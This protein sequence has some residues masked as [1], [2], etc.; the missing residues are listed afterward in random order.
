MTWGLIRAES[1]GNPYLN[2]A[3]EEFLFKNLSNTGYEGFVRFWR[4]DN[5]VV[6]GR[7]QCPLSEVNYYKAMEMRTKVVRRFTGGGAVYHDQGNLNFTLVF[8]SNNKR[9][10]ELF[11]FV[12]NIVSAAL[13]KMGFNAAFKP[14]NDVLVGP[15]KVAG[16][17]GGIQGNIVLVHG[18]LLVN[19]NLEALATVL[20]V[21][22]EKLSDKA[23]ES[24]RRRVTT[25]SSEVGRE[26]SIK[27]VEES[28]LC[29]VVTRVGIRD[30]QEVRLTKVECVLIDKLCREK[31]LSRDWLALLCTYCPLRAEHEEKVEALA[32]VTEL[33]KSGR[34]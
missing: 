6:I 13:K 10:P 14:I 11:E 9:L 16:L 28:L 15:K 23:V 21:S 24:V 30:L 17:A 27:E 31:Y 3:L 19:S 33:D 22:K 12:G 29:E 32:G 18:C 2:M 34:V 7:F 4:N 25:L 1:P 8:K 20:N 26:V 5:V